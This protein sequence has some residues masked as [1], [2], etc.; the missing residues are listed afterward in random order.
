MT[1]LAAGCKSAVFP[2]GPLPHHGQHASF[3][4]STRTLNF[5]AISR[6][7][8]AKHHVRGS[9]HNRNRVRMSSVQPSTFTS[10]SSV[11]P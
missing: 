4:T 2:I 6:Q 1:D 3:S 9:L 11:S 8:S 7:S 10:N 5:S